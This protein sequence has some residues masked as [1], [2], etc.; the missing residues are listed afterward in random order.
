MNQQELDALGAILGQSA[1]I[2]S[3]WKERPVGSIDSSVIRGEIV[4]NY[5]NRRQSPPSQPL[6]I[7][8][9]SP[10]SPEIVNPLTPDELKI[11]G[12]VPL[13][14]EMSTG[15]PP[16]VP[17]QPLQTPV[18]ASPQMEFNF[19]PSKQDVMIDLLR[20]IS[21]KLTKVI[22]SLSSK[23]EDAVRLKAKKE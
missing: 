8:P 6:P 1:Q 7:P 4:K 19:D 18:E 16:P 3:M 5:N 17:F 22:D 14:P 21:K 20:E 13:I 9:T 12:N 2:D 23:Q 11:I 15:T 10:I